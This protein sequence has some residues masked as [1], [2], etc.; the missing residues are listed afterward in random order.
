M[1]MSNADITRLAGLL[2]LGTP[3]HVEDN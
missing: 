2:P 3:V 1:R